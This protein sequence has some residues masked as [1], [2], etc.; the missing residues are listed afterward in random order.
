[1]M[2]D[3]VA[4]VLVDHDGHKIDSVVTGADAERAIA[5]GWGDGH[6]SAVKHAQKLAR[7]SKRKSG[8][9]DD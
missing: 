7:Q 6:P 9:L 3:A 4:R 1:M 2:A 5:E 8:E